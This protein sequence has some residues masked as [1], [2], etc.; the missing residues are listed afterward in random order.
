MEHSLRIIFEEFDFKLMTQ[1]TETN[2]FCEN[3]QRSRETEQKSLRDEVDRLRAKLHSQDIEI[4]KLKVHLREER[5]RLKRHIDQRHADIDQEVDVRYKHEV[6]T[7]N[8]HRE[9][10][11]QILDEHQNT[12]E[13]LQSKLS[14]FSM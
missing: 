11:E 12:I 5:A 7:L 4:S 2:T 9:Q 13:K 3:L 10:L 8:A 1:T 6:D 14:Q